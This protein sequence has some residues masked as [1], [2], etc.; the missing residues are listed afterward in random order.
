[1]SNVTHNILIGWKPSDSGQVKVNCDGAATKF[2]ET[3]ATAADCIRDEFGNF[4]IGYASNFVCVPSRWPRFEQFFLSCRQGQAED[5]RVLLMNL[6][7][8]QH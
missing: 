4:I 1:M 2:C 8:R 7:Q 5:T 6:I 3:A